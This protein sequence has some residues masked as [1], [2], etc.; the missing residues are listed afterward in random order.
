M[1]LI[2]Q[3]EPLTEPLAERQ[4][5]AHML[6][7]EAGALMWAPGAAP[8]APLVLRD[9]APDAAAYPIVELPARTAAG[10][11]RR[12]HYRPA[13]GVIYSDGGIE[14][15]K[16]LSALLETVDSAH[17]RRARAVGAAPMSLIRAVGAASDAAGAAS[18]AAGAIGTVVA[19]PRPPYLKELPP[20]PARDAR[21]ARLLLVA[22][23][24]ETDPPPYSVRAVF[25]WV[26]LP[27]S[28]V[29]AISARAAHNLSAGPVNALVAGIVY[30]RRRQFAFANGDT[31]QLVLATDVVEP[32]AAAGWGPPAGALRSTALPPALADLR[33]TYAFRIRLGDASCI[34][35]G[36]AAGTAAPG[37]AAPGAVKLT[38]VGNHHTLVRRPTALAAAAAAFEGLP[39][40]EWPADVAGCTRGRRGSRCATCRVPVGGAVVLVTDASCPKTGYVVIN[41]YRRD[42]RALSHRDDFLEA[43][44]NLSAGAPLARSG[45][46]S[47][48]ICSDCWGAMDGSA[49]SSLRA[50]VARVIVPWSQAE[51]A[52]AMG[53]AGI[54]ALLAAEVRRTAVA[55]AF[56]A[57]IQCQDVGQAPIRLVLAGANL[58]IWPA[59]DCPE[60]PAGIVVPGLNIVTV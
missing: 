33:P 7:M 53:L 4:L 31:P 41:E 13:T 34:R 16:R 46:Q 25:T 59:L 5:A 60:L 11:P 48:L 29:L 17:L 21:P 43:I 28:A 35:P 8:S 9:A 19:G 18:D 45:A 2:V 58:G 26:F 15:A 47:A 37:T 44:A 1:P 20:G 50:R 36:D 32:P 42:S 12:V 22:P 3:A 30:D 51:A 6:N 27:L 55:A 56:T 23:D 57:D 52:E 38:L 10:R 40:V 49:V 24:S 39:L 14:L 54:A